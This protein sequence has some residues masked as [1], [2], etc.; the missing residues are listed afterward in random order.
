MSPR[1]SLQHVWVLQQV[2]ETQS[3]APLQWPLPV[4]QTQQSQSGSGHDWL[5]GAYVY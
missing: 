4:E 3:P 2:F 5:V 1:H